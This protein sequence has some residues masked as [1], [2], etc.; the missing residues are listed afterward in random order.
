MHKNLFILIEKNLKN[1]SKG[2][3]LIG[4][5]ILENYP[6][7]A[8]L[9]AS[10]LGKIVGVSESTVVRFATELGFN[11]YPELQREIRSL[12]KNK[13]TS[14]QRVEFAQENLNKGNLL[15]SVLNLDIERIRKTLENSNFQNFEETVEKITAAKNIYIIGSKSSAFIANFFA[16]NLNLI[17]DNVIKINPSGMGEI[18]EQIVRIGE[19]D[20]IVGISFPRYSKQTVSAFKYAS[21]N[22]ACVIALTDNPSSPLTQ[23]AD[24]SLFAQ[25]DMVSFVDSLVAPLSILNA[26]IV[27]LS[28]KNKD[29]VF[30]NLEKLENIWGEYEVYI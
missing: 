4:E 9:T 30:E 11:G 7:V 20:V 3:K 27:A 10:R 18:F 16:Y 14:V 6:K 17:F 24:I 26:I 2:H 29:K 8:S 22:G 5:Y 21:E 28:I 25:S 15:E 23:Y 12:M 13:L 19:N 1:F